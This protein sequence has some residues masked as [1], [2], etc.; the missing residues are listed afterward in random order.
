MMK[1]RHLIQML[2]SSAA[3]SLIGSSGLLSACGS[4]HDAEGTD[5]SLPQGPALP[6][7]DLWWLSG[8]YAPVDAF[9]SDELQVIGSLPPELSGTYVR[10]GPNPPRGESAHWFTGDGMLHGVRI[11]GGEALWYR[12]H[13]ITTAHYQDPPEPGT[14]PDLETHQANTSVIEHG[15]RWLCLSEAGL[16]YEVNAELETVGVF[17]YDGALDHPVSA[18]PKHDPVSGDLNLFGYTIAPS[19]LRY[20]R[21]DASGQI[22]D[23]A[24]VQLS[25][26]TMIHDF[27]V[28]SDYI[29]FM[30][31]PVI[32]DFELALGG[33]LMPFR[34]DETHQARIGLIPRGDDGSGVLW[35]EIDPCFVF[36][37]VNAYHSA[38]RPEEVILSGVRYNKLWV[39]SADDFGDGG[40][41]WEWTINVESGLVTS[42]QLDEQRVEFPVI[43][44]EYQSRA[45]RY[46]YA[47]TTGELQ[48]DV[49]LEVVKFDAE[50]GV[51][52]SSQFEGKY[53]LG[54]LKFIPRADA[55]Q[56]DEGWLMGYA[57]N[58]ETRLSELIILDAQDLKRPPVA[59]VLLPRRVPF[60][61]HG[62]WIKG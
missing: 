15:G 51:M 29:V 52:S 41:L 16:P 61:F 22:S 3:W 42:R 19:Q 34:W 25:S 39:D 55:S 37:T 2:G 28:T 21:I 9:E 12:A 50:A 5:S 45:H 11:E 17:D 46:S 36:H 47:L 10:N 4:D 33:D 56:E 43:N 32:L 14:L 48:G 54:E 35:F 30:D 31:L 18:H 38:D 49:A 6:E 13:Y 20:H 7:N 59:R 62:A 26:P 44:P 53:Q 58:T 57:Y 40:R 60:G 1:R 27:Q 24:S 23:S 8:N